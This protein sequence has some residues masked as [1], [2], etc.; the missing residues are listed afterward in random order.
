MAKVYRS[1]P[2]E[3]DLGRIPTARAGEYELSDREVQTARRRIYSINKD[4]G[5]GW[6]FRTQREGS[7]LLVW[8]VK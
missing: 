7:L 5:A 1:I 4:N 8:K 2:T 6:R 3:A